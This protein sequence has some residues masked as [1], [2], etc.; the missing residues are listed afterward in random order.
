MKE[1]ILDNDNKC[2][3]NSS[4]NSLLMRKYLMEL[5]YYRWR[6]PSRMRA[7]IKDGSASHL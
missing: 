4:N 6:N 2:K 5:K 3:Y 7:C 1:I